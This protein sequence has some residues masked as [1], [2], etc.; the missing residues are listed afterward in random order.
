MR[1]ALVLTGVLM[2]AC[3]QAQVPGRALPWDA[4][5]E[6][7]W[8]AGERSPAPPPPPSSAPAP[9]SAS[10]RVVH[11]SPH[12]V[13][14]ILDE[15]GLVLLRQ[16]LPGRP[17]RLWRDAGIPVELTGFPCDFPGETP[18]SRGA[19]GMIL[20]GGDFRPNL[21]GLLW[22]LD[23]GGRQLT[24]VH[25]ATGQVAF[26]PLPGGRDQELILY[27]DH[28]EVR[29]TPPEPGNR[30]ET[31]CWSVPWVGLLPQLLKLSTPPPAPPPG[32]A[33]IPFSREE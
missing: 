26:L 28:L 29:D 6:P 20:E 21:H 10:K 11:L 1:L 14:K 3:L 13:L 8:R 4:Q 2:A 15:R 5:P 16:G 19:E 24:V 27:P 23:D 30:M 32:T 33:L 9:R 12:G 31:P 18:L 7:P 17:L 25:P 22:I